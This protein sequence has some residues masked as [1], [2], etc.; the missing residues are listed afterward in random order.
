MVAVVGGLRARFVKDSCYHMING[1]LTQLGWFN[2][3]A[4]H[5]PITFVAT[6]QDTT[7]EIPYNTLAL[8]D[9]GLSTQPG[10]IGSNFADHTWP[11]YLDFFA[12]NDTVGLHMIRD[13]K[14]VLEGRM[15]SIGRTTSTLDVLDWTKATPPMLFFVD[16][17]S[18]RV[19]RAHGF[20]E[21]YL[22]HWYSCM[23][24]IVDHYGDELDA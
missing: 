5:S 20:A 19:D 6:Q 12:E 1:A 13:M 21:P 18:V 16:I 11:F 22:R 4:Y 10:E 14:D 7:T 15:P 17:E 8:A 3:S 2:T 23:F 24:D 9:E